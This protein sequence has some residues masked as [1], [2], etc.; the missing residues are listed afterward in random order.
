MKAII[1]NIGILLRK[2]RDKQLLAVQGHCDLCT[3]DIK[4]SKKTKVITIKLTPKEV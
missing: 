3:I 1:I 4:K 2:L